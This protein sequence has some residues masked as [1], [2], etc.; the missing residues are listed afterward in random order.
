M[1]SKPY[2]FVLGIALAALLLVPVASFGAEEPVVVKNY[3]NAL[4]FFPQVEAE[5]MILTVTGPCNYKIRR[6]LRDDGELIYKL[7]ETTIDGM[8]RFEVTVIPRIDGGIIEVLQDA[9]KTGDNPEVDKLCREGSL[10]GEPLIQTA[11]FRVANAPIKWAPT[12]ST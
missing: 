6:S 9:R 5:D 8:Y 4:Q 7:D 1:Y 10:P 3:G 12:R 11:G 2:R